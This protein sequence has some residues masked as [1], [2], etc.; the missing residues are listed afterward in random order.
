MKKILIENIL[1]NIFVLVVLAFTFVYVDDFLHSVPNIVN[2]QIT[3]QVLILFISIISAAACTGNF[4]FTYEKIN[5]FSRFQRLLAHLT[6]GLLMLVIGV[7]F[8][9]VSVL[10]KLM[11]GQQF[12]I[13]DLSLLA[14]YVASILYD[15]WDLSRIKT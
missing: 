6:T 7:S 4:A 8:E 13:L 10:V 5:S 15:F 14:L 12:I 3:N 2:D 11:I 1:K 9:M